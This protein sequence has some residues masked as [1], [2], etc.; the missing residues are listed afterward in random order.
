MTNTASLASGVV[1]AH[2]GTSSFGSVSGLANNHVPRMAQFCAD[3][4]RVL[5]HFSAL[6][7]FSGASTGGSF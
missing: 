7:C 1:G 6:R 4:G 5:K 3:G 2:L